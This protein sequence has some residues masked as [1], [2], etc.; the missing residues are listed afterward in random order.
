MKNVFYLFATILLLAL[1]LCSCGAQDSDITPMNESYAYTPKSDTV[2]C[3]SLVVDWAFK[4]HISTE[5]EDGTFK[6]FT[7]DT[8]QATAFINSQRTLLK[9]LR[10]YGVD[11]AGLTYFGTNYDGSFSESS[12]GEV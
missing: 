5:T 8:A 11:T 10:E 3:P 6:C 9:L 4:Y 12:K 7:S 2:Y 1:L